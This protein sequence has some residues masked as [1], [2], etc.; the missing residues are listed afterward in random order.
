MRVENS[1][2]HNGRNPQYPTYK[3]QEQHKEEKTEDN[4][5]ETLEL[6][7]ETTLLNKLLLAKENTF[8]PLPFY[9]VNAV[10]KNVKLGCEISKRIQNQAQ[11]LGY[12][13]N[14]TMIYDMLMDIASQNQFQQLT[15]TSSEQQ[16]LNHEEKLLLEGLHQICLDNKT[17]EIIIAT[18]AM[19]YAGM[20]ILANKKLSKRGC[21]EFIIQCLK[22]ELSLN[23][24]IKKAFSEKLK[25][26]IATPSLLYP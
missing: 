6:S 23:A 16:I 2:G 19:E 14:Y 10:A 24:T 4:Q 25:R 7:P 9:F 26:Y 1:H 8:I 20:K 5:Q 3:Q 22:K 17:N 18:V 21:V 11:S 13:L 12:T 15:K